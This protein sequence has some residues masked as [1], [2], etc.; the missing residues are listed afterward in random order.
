MLKLSLRWMVRLAGFSAMAAIA[1]VVTTSSASGQ[2]AP[3]T[4]EVQKTANGDDAFLPPMWEFELSSPQDGCSSQTLS[5]PSARE[6]QFATVRGAFTD[7]VWTDNDGDSCAY[8]VNEISLPAGWRQPAPAEL[9]VTGPR[10]GY[11]VVVN[12]HIETAVGELRILGMGNVLVPGS[13]VDTIEFTSSCL[14]E[15]LA[16][17]VPSGPSSNMIE[18]EVPLVDADGVPCQYLADNPE[19]GITMW[20]PPATFSLEGTYPFARV[21]F[22][23]LA[24][25]GYPSQPSEPAVAP[26]PTST[27]GPAPAPQPALAVVPTPTAVSASALARAVGPTSVVAVVGDPAPTA[28]VSPTPSR[29]ALAVTGGEARLMALLGL[30]LLLVGAGLFALSRT[31]TSQKVR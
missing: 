26:T 30:A 24:V 27:A 21:L 8:V 16:V 12:H 29:P 28:T 5:I 6:H 18:V 20:N 11:V 7:V 2:E 3:N 13:G 22:T 19:A 15:P 1:I 10:T 14:T 31:T 17:E 4:I 9:I 25:P 23:G